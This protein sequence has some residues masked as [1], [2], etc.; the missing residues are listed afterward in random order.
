MEIA[1]KELARTGGI[2]GLNNINYYYMKLI[3]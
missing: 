3:Y 2:A 1:I